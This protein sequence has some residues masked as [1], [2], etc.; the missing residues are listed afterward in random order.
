MNEEIT[1]ID[2][3]KHLLSIMFEEDV[4][5]TEAMYVDF[6]TNEIDMKSVFDLVDYLEAKLENL[7]KVQ[8][9]MEVWSGT[10]P[11]VALKR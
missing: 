8:Y 11:D 5:L 7:D 9:Y 2:Y 4:T 10:V 6:W 3:E 1:P